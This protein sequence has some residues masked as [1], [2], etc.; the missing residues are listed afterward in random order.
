MEFR[1]YIEELALQTLDEIMAKRTKLCGC[2]R[3]RLDTVALALNRLSPKYA[4]T[5]V[6]RAH[7]KLEA[8]K[9]QFQTDVVKELTKALEQVKA[10]PRHA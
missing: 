2:Q 3:C 1:N 10:N 9:A 6:G 4:V 7:V 8:T 5:D